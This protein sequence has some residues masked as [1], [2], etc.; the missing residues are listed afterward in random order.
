MAGYLPS[1]LAFIAIFLVSLAFILLSIRAALSGSTNRGWLRT[2]Y[3][4]VWAVIGLSLVA[5]IEAI[6]SFARIV[7]D[8]AV[9]NPVVRPLTA[10]DYFVWGGV[11]THALAVG[12]TAA[13]LIFGVRIL[14]DSLAPKGRV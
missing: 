1:K 6:Y 14:T 2:G 8:P 13:A 3:H 11:A 5:A 4:A 7:F 9:R 12:L 10:E